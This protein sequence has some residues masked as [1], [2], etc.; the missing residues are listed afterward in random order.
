VNSSV[1]LG[2]ELVEVLS[3]RRDRSTLFIEVVLVSEKIHPSVEVEAFS[4]NMRPSWGRLI[5]E[6]D[7]MLRPVGVL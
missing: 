3:K 4:K 7:A 2:F 6:V 1:Q 5:W